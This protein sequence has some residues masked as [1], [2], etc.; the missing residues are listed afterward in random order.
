MSDL[1][2]WI[3]GIAG[4]IFVTGVLYAGDS[5]W[6][7]KT[8]FESYQESQVLRENQAELRR[9]DRQVVEIQSE[10]QYGNLTPERKAQLEQLLELLLQQQEE[11]KLE[12][13]N[14]N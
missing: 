9:L 6:L 12:I 11:L 4:A 10:L 2:K 7:A 5:R 1:V 14:G 13:N 8:A 3:I